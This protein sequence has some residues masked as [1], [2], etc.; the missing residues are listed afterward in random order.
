MSG[1]IELTVQI[2]NR[3]ATAQQR[4]LAASGWG[5]ADVT[6]KSN[7][8]DYVKFSPFFPIG[9]IDIPGNEDKTASVE[10]AWQG[11]KVFENEG[12]DARKYIITSMKNIK[13]KASAASRGRVLGHMYEG[14][15]IG[16]IE[17]RKKI[18]IP[19]YNSVLERLEPVLA[20][21]LQFASQHH[22]KLVLLDYETNTNINDGSKPL[23]HASLV[24]Q[25]LREMHT[26]VNIA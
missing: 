4:T 19:M 9:N 2:L 21:I 20:D 11:L 8:P 24:A 12:I 15:T 14:R 13:R 17:S 25:A 7:H 16:Y 6:S 22:G 10:G 3:R 18:Y 26:R 5:I 1:S 23:S